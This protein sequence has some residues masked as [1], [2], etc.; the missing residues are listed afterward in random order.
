MSRIVSIWLK[1]WPIA[2]LLRAKGFTASAD[3][4]D[5]YRPLVLVAPGKGGARIF[6]CNKVARRQG[7]MIGDLLSNARSKVLDLQTC[8][9]DPA[10]DAAALRQL[11]LWALRYTPRAAA[12]DE[13]SGADGLFLDI[14]GCAHLF[15]GEECLLADISQ[16]L[17]RFEL[18]VR[19]AVADTAGAAWAVARHGPAERSIVDPSGQAEALRDLPLAAL[20]FSDAALSLLRRLGIRRVGEVM[21]QPRAPF[22]ARFDGDLLL[23]LD[24][25]LGVAPE[26]LTPVVSPPIYRAQTMFLEPIT[27]E[28]HVLEA[29]RHLLRQVVP[30]LESDDAGARALRVLLFRVD[31]GV[32]KLDLGFAA[33][34]RD[35][36]HMMRLM[37]LR[38]ERT[39]S[40][41]DAEFGFE[42]AAMHVVRA[43]RL[44]ARES[45]LCIGDAD[46]QPEALAQLIDRLRQRLG[47]NAVRQLR[48]HQS[49]VPERAEGA[50]PADTSWP[51]SKPLS[52]SEAINVRCASR[53]LLL[54]PQPEGAQVMALIPD[55]PP[56]RFRWRGV[57]Y[58]VVDAEG[59]E[60]ITPEWWR[61]TGANERDYYM[62]EDTEG[63]RFWLYRDGLYGGEALPQWFVHGV[64][65]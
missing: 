5:P 30:Q 18:P 50:V 52:E 15:G 26:P 55:G 7:L 17:R 14:T 1:A 10:A 12:W 59:P 23:R 56:L 51:G 65:A 61:R 60:R 54:L 37:A 35:V 20:R 6:A 49:H 64:F 13:A 2:R 24:Q 34:S 43:D 46:S 45:G 21:S 32:V 41:F 62:V 48:P 33:P 57:M 29:A 58:Q 39:A 27:S 44:G 19:V 47:R 3:P 25:A 31:G 63:H 11:A 36:E 22:A 38:L 4:P 53:P 40:G 16:R 9:A 8:D 28:E 42:A